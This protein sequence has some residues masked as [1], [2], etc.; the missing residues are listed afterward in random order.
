LEEAN[1]LAEFIH[2]LESPWLR[3][4]R[5][6]DRDDPMRRIGEYVYAVLIRLFH[7][8]NTGRIWRSTKLVL[9]QSLSSVKVTCTRYSPGTG[10]ECEVMGPLVLSR[11]PSSKSHA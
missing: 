1:G 3:S 6:L 7:V 8:W 11:E 10:K 2:D 5:A 9:S 4:Q